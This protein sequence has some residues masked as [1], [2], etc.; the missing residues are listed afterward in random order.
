MGFQVV[1]VFLQVEEEYAAAFGRK[2]DQRRRALGLRVHSLHL[3]ATYFDM[4][5]AYPRMRQETRA[6]FMRL[7]EIAALLE[8]RGL[9]W[10]G[11]RYSLDDPRAVAAFLESAA[12]AAEQAQSAGVTLC[13]EN[14]SWCYL[15]TPAHV[16]AL[17]AADLPIGFTFDAFQAGESGIDPSAL[18]EAMGGRLLTVHAADYAPGRP[19]HLPPG[20]GCLDW[21]RIVRALVQ[22]AYSGPLILEPAHV[23]DPTV[24]LGAR[25][26]LEA[27]L[28]R[29]SA[30]PSP[31]QA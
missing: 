29:E 24:L 20:E 19:R 6:R 27:V 31:G 30:P 22:A 21:H 7:L 9:T 10:H 13:I 18:I 4:W 5:A 23:A 25:Q 28:A 3:Y 26:F 12:W 2:L 11:L 17:V 8:V 14:V 16:R 15:R 1:E